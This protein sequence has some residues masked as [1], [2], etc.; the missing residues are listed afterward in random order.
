MDPSRLASVPRHSLPT[1]LSPPSLDTRA[2]EEGLERQLLDALSVLRHDW[3]QEALPIDQHFS[4]I[5]SPALA[6]YESER[7]TGTPFGSED[8]QAVIKRYTPVGHT[9]KAF[10]AQFTHASPSKIIATLRSNPV[11]QDIISTLGGD[12]AFA[13]RVHVTAYAEDT[14]AVWVIL[15]VRYRANE[16]EAASVQGARFTPS[17]TPAASRETTPYRANRLGV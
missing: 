1:V 17:S 8:F 4:Y 11:A 2:L 9:F 10:P 16:D 13:L 12:L 5:L 14:T 15:G 7:L 6:A 3:T